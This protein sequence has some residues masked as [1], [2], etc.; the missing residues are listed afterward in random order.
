MRQQTMPGELDWLLDDLVHRVGGVRHAL[1]L[2]ED[3]LVL[4]TSGNITRED[5]GF[6]AA[7]ASGF[8]R[9]AGGVREHYRARRVQ[10]STVELDDMLF[11]VVP[12]GGGNCLAVL[13]DKGGNA[14]LVAY[15][16]TMLIR[17]LQGQPTAPL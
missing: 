3:G 11:F 6:L 5:A 1:L 12:A 4:A 9:L 8:D 16:A 2:A 14:G 10:Q 7:L 13:S 17:R 15:E